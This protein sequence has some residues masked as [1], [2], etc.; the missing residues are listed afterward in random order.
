MLI[1][2]KSACAAPSV[3]DIRGKIKEWHKQLTAANYIPLR[4][5]ISVSARYRQEC[6]FHVGRGFAFI[7]ADYKEMKCAKYEEMYQ[8]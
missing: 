8:P 1:Y 5:W 4:S 3:D 2:P 6:Y 7:I